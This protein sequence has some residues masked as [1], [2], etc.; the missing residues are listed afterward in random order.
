MILP[1]SEELNIGK[2]SRMF[3]SNRVSNCYKFFW[4]LAILEKID[5]AKTVFSYDEL[6]N[7]MIVKAWYMVTEFNLKLGPCN[8][9]DN[10]EEVVKYIQLTYGFASTEKAEKIRTFL[11]N[12]DDKR[13]STYKS[14]LINN[15]P[16]CLQTPF[17]AGIKDP[18]KN[19]IDLINSQEHLLYY[20]E[21]FAKTNTRIMVSDEWVLYLIR[22][23]EIL[24]SWVEYNL[25]GYLQRKNPNVPG[26]AD[27]IHKPEKR[28]L[29]RVQS[30][31]S[32]LI[33]L[34][35]SIQDIYGEVPMMD[36]KISIDHFVPW[37]YVSHDE[38]WNL[39]PTTKNI[40]S[41]KSNH[42]PSWDAYFDRLATLEHRAYA[43]CQKND[44][45]R[46]QFLK[47]ADYHIN[48]LD[49]RVNLYA[50]NLTEEAFKTRLCNVVKPVYDAAKNCGFSEWVYL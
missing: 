32:L 13:I 20:F 36:E 21:A 28:D 12:T 3:D 27:K 33:Q 7:E 2:L 37:Q 9:T 17:Y 29:K 1:F 42:L 23:R 35:P 22:N 30:Y 31:W 40:N 38:L 16:Y 47:C 44:S 8:T 18:D 39:S 15:V 46:Q 43:L 41:S 11:E 50:D 5:E 34:D 6:L 4:M 19:K 26:I 24:K 25:I 45:A 48:S 10:L 14:T 49:V